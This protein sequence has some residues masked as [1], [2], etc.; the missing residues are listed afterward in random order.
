MAR[1]EVKKLMIAGLKDEQLTLL[2]FSIP[3]ANKILKWKHDKEFQYQGQMYDVVKKEIRGDS[4]FYVC[5][6]DHKETLLN[7]Q[8]DQ[9]VKI[10][11]GSSPHQEK[12]ERALIFLRNL[13]CTLPFSWIIDMYA[14]EQI[15]FPS[16]DSPLSFFIVSPS[17]LPPET[18]SLTS[19]L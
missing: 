13:Y 4:I 10:N 11:T 3:E 2:S 16:Y 1:R 6:W 19:V 15:Q 9:L 14:N 18:T 17:L 5:W 12:Q 7:K 8:L